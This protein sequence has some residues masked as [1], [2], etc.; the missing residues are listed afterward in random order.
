MKAKFGA[1][2]VDGRGKIGGHVASKN[3]FGNYFRT[4]VTPVN[5]QTQ[6]QIEARQLFQQFTTGWGQLTPAQIAAWNEKANQTAEINIFGDTVYP[7]GKG[8]YIQRNVNLTNSG[9]T[10][11]ANAPAEV[12]F[13]DGLT[14]SVATLQAGLVEIDI[15]GGAVAPGTKVLIYAAG[16]IP[17]GVTFVKNKLRLLLNGT[18]SDMSTSVD[19]TNEFV[20]IFGQP[21]TGLKSQFRIVQI[22]S[23][24]KA[25]AP[26]IA[27]AIAT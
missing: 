15:F 21:V 1:I 22:S 19:V 8:L 26:L 6:K 9:Q 18:V 20:A 25:S 14:T 27:E 16:N 17:N 5:P 23:A 7:T 13:Q 24:G 10:T 11:T 3:R 12:P 4:K 2:V